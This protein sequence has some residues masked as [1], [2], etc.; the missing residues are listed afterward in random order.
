[1]QD[2][3]RR[4]CVYGGPGSGKTTYAARLFAD[5]KTMGCEVEHVQEFVKTM[6]YEG[7]K[8]EGFDQTYILGE[9]IHREEVALRHVP[10]I[11]T[12]CP[13]PLCAAYAKYY[14]SLGWG[15]ILDMAMVYDHA[16][17]ALN[18]YVKR[19][20]PYTSKGR[21]QTVEQAREFDVFLEG[22]LHD[23]LKAYQ[24]IDVTSSEFKL[25]HDLKQGCMGG[26]E[27]DPTQ[28]CHELFS[29]FTRLD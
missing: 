17:P 8:P 4:V 2:R 26:K 20:V 13:V 28:K 29:G 15:A 23:H 3:V 22:F 16:F 19:S 21:Y 11:V 10:M 25:L 6:A 9:Q 5:L 24:T 14:V 18:L 12:D 1:M 27:I 7:R